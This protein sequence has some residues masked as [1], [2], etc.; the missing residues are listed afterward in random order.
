MGGG[1]S[2]AEEQEP[3]GISLANHYCGDPRCGMICLRM[4]G[5]RIDEVGGRMVP[6]VELDPTEVLDLIAAL[7][8]A[9]REKVFPMPEGSDRGLFGEPLEPDG[10]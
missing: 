1:D 10:A 7:A 9:S 2:P 6:S 8:R 3:A 4:H 5:A